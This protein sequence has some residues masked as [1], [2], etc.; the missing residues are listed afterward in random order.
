[1]AGHAAESGEALAD[2][3]HGVVPTLERVLRVDRRP[4][5]AGDDLELLL[6]PTLSIVCF[7]YV[8]EGGRPDAEVDAAAERFITSLT[9][10]TT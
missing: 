6:E 2:Q 7:R 5:H 10:S 1:M 9:A 4:P 3:A 8:P